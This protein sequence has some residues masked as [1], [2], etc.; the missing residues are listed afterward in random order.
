MAD[1]ARELGAALLGRASGPAAGAHRRVVR[2]VEDLAW[3]DRAAARDLYDLWTLA[4]LGAIDTAAAELFT[5]HGPT[6]PS[7][8]TELFRAAPTEERWRRDLGGQLRLEVTAAD[9]LTRVRAAWR[10]VSTADA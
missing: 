8:S 6:N 10:A 5:R 7:P 4:R 2:G 9:A 1:R 3:A